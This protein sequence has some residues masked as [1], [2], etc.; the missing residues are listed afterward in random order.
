M[1]LDPYRDTTWKHLGYVRHGGRWMS[2]EQIQAQEKEDA[3]QRLADRHWEP[4]LKRWKAWLGEKI[5][6]DEAVA[7]LAGIDD[8][9]AVPA[10]DRVF[11]TND[12]NDQERAVKLLGQIRSPGSSQE[13]AFLAVR[14]DFE[15]V[16]S[17]AIEAL[18][19]R[20]PRDYAENLVKMIHGPWTYEA[21]AVNGPGSNGS[22]VVDSAKFHVVRTYDAPAP[23]KL[24]SS[25]RGYVGIDPNGL[26]IVINGRDLDKYYSKP[27]EAASIL[28]Q[29]ERQ[30]AEMLTT[31]QIKA[32]TAQQRLLADIQD[33][34]TNNAILEIL[35]PRIAAVL[36]GTL[37]AP[38]LGDDEDAWQSWWYERIGYRFT[39]TPKAM[40]AQNA[41]PQYPA[42]L[43]VSCF[44]AGTPVKTREGRKPIE[45]IRVGDQ[46]LSQDAATGGLA[47][48][49]VLAIHHNP[50]DQTLRITLDE[51]DPIVASRFHR[52]W[53]V[54]RGW[55]MARD[56]QTGDVVRTLGGPLKVKTI[57]PG[58]VVPVFNLDVA[59]SR[60]YFVG[61]RD[62][63]VHDNTL[64]DPHAP[65]FDAGPV[66]AGSATR[67]K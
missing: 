45:E 48:Q 55:K 58:P 6:R 63:L 20:E 10:I 17:M 47:F 53:L 27:K 1:G 23:F 26:P 21:M 35:N 62:S 12:R 67:T 32:Q 50:P 41:V 36:K 5:H 11:V 34:E 38:D 39:P 24:G 52:F 4:L 31:A 22:L 28:A 60:T 9:R 19:G 3:A 16:R 61:D 51:G 40:L 57:E 25:F 2:H 13:L 29:D 56:L 8:P 33:I 42:P 54:G 18:E 30:T 44:A 43:I 46:V 65:I 15:P 14:S 7:H 37:D 64:P 66:L 49:S 59:R